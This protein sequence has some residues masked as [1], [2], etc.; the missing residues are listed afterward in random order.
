MKAVY[1]YL[2]L[3]ALTY[4]F[5][6][7]YLLVMSFFNKAFGASTYNDTVGPIS[8]AVYIQ[9]GAKDG[10]DKI[11]EKF[12]N[13]GLKTPLAL[14]LFGYQTYKHKAIELKRINNPLLHTQHAISLKR[15][16]AVIRTEWKF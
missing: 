8:Q 3:L 4:T 13:K 1:R 6:F 10:V 16:E 7:G 9:S 15:N 12:E 5:F 14:A 11:R 2:C